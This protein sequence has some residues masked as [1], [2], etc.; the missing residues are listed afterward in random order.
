MLL[1]INFLPLPQV[2]EPNKTLT[3]KKPSKRPVLKEVQVH[4]DESE[5]D[6]EDP[7]EF[8]ATLNPKAPAFVPQA[9]SLQNQEMT[10]EVSGDLPEEHHTREPLMILENENARELDPE[11]GSAEREPVEGHA[12]V[13]EP[14]ER[15][16]E[17]PQGPPLNK[18]PVLQEMEP[19][20]GPPANVQ[21]CNCFHIK[22]TALM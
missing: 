7:G 5:S 8:V 3:A 19:P 17:L 1:P 14:V 10:V 13:A 18:N 11:V 15:R 22:A 12:V 20:E 9:H 2:S 6:S 4:S 21:P 16:V